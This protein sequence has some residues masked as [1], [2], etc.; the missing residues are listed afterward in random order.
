MH[1][2]LDLN[3]V[4]R[5]T[6]VS[7]I[8]RNALKKMIARVLDVTLREVDKIL[9]HAFGS[10]IL[11]TFTFGDIF[12]LANVDAFT[13]AAQTAGII[14][15]S[16]QL[17]RVVNMIA[18]ITHATE[19]CE[20]TRCGEFPIYERGG[21]IRKDSPNNLCLYCGHL[22]TQPISVDTSELDPVLMN[23]RIRQLSTGQSGELATLVKE[24][25]GIRKSLEIKKDVGEDSGVDSSLDPSHAWYSTPTS[26]T[27][28]DWR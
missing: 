14:I 23:G 24:V 4:S 17:F 26:G 15:P 22:R 16:V 11:N 7:D 5:T 1:R 13:H 19:T 8:K 21:V 27:G 12:D 10:H 18:Q 2:E 28:L 25:R 20:N 6:A 3:E 9:V